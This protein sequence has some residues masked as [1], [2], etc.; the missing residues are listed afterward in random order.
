MPNQV[1]YFSAMLRVHTVLAR[2]GSALEIF[3]WNKPGMPTPELLDK[4]YKK[5]RILLHPDK[6]VQVKHA[7]GVWLRVEAAYEELKAQ[8]SKKTD[9]EVD[10]DDLDQ[11][12]R[13]WEAK[14]RERDAELARAAK[15]RE[16]AARAARSAGK[17]RP[18]RSGWA[19]DSYTRPK[20]KSR[21]KDAPT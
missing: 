16:E 10:D 1:D 18:G 14:T 13:D 8:L 3:G 6:H 9:G 4:M 15:E 19:S 20:G 21:K 17:K 11:V 2:G 12:R 7:H 5:L